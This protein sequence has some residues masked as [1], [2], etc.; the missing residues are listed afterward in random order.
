MAP[1]APPGIGAEVEGL[2]AVSAAV[3]AGRVTKL[4]VAAA[5][6]HGLADLIATARQKG[7]TVDVI[8]D[9]RQ[10]AMTSA[11]QGVVARCRPLQT[12]SLD[13]AI[14][15]SS[16]AALVM[17]DHL[18][19]PRNVGAV[20]RSAVAAGFTGMVMSTR[21]SAPLSAASFKAAAGALEHLD[22]VEVS[23]IAD[24]VEQARKREVWSV[25]LDSDGT[26]PLFGMNLFTEPVIVV[27]GAE[28]VGLSRLVAQRVDVVA[29]IPIAP[30]VES[31]NASVAAALALFEVARVRAASSK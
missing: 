28:G 4:T 6:K 24:A 2:H 22:L 8:D 7:A 19:D 3:D 10:L 17:L 1:M 13:A 21:R 16:P 5:R 27:I 20:A 29:S 25:G 12:V 26:Q 14:D 31:L 15:R 18:E 11:P 9:V 23:S 30:K